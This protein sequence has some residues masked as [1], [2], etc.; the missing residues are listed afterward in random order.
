MAAP[1][2]RRTGAR[3]GPAALVAALLL[4]AACVPHLLVNVHG[5]EHHRDWRVGVP[6]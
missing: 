5:S 6:F 4:A 2:H 3:I 1:R